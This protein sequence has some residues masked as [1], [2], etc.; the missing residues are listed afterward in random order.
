MTCCKQHTHNA[1]LRSATGGFLDSHAAGA[2]LVSGA[3]ASGPPNT[4]NRESEKI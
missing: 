2:V 1:S 3:W 4:I